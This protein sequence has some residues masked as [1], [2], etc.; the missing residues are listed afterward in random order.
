MKAAL[1]S[2]ATFLAAAALFAWPAAPSAEEEAVHAAV[3]DYVEAIYDVEPDRIARSV[4]PELRK[5]GFWRND[6]AY[7][8][9]D[10]SYEQLH[11]LAARWNT[12]N[13]QNLDESTVKK[14]EV[15]DVLDQT[16]TAKLT[17]D[18]GV[19]YFHLARFDGQWQIVNVMWQ[20]PPM[21]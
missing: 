5:L 14:I 3:L 10:M 15:Y 11:A 9:M 7:Q 19:D 18:W 17:A 8:R 4:H 13:R 6:G 1:S 21:K 16:A 2:L 20:S 12:D